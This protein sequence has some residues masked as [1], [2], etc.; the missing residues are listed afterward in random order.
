VF[1]AQS[2][3]LLA[4]LHHSPAS[5]AQPPRELVVGRGG[6]VLSTGRVVVMM[7]DSPS[8]EQPNRV[9]AVGRGGG[10]VVVNKPHDWQLERL[11]EA[12]LG[13][14]AAF[15]HNLDRPTSGCMVA[16]TTPEA[17]SRVGILWQAGLVAKIYVALVEGHCPPSWHEHD[18]AELDF[19]IE[20]SQRRSMQ[21][22]KANGKR[23]LTRVRLAA[24]AETRDG[25]P[26]SLVWCQPVTG[27]RHQLRV[28]LAHALHPIVGD[29]KYGARPLGEW[30]GE[31]LS[32]SGRTVF[33]HAA[34]IAVPELQE[35]GGLISAVSPLN[36][37]CWHANGGLV[38][39][40]ELAPP[41]ASWFRSCCA[42]A[43]VPRGGD[44]EPVV[45]S[46]LAAELAAQVLT[47][48][49]PALFDAN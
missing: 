44:D 33:L 41:P 34:S 43:E 13:V 46:G 32:A 30:P 45:E 29:A 35:H 15:C 48:F 12:E 40:Q 9:L 21:K 36:A 18:G 17:A 42:A 27:R 19:R 16:A 8:V 47:I 10:V 23:A 49:D 3:L 31:A 37:G 5:A 2:C 25:E 11:A 22:V 7:N 28:H 26:V 39:T 38:L 14:G 4:V 20:T 1:L 24:H 6:V